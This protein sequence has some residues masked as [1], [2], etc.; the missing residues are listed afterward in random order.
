MSVRFYVADVL[1]E[2]KHLPSPDVVFARGV[3]HTFK[4]HKGRTAFAE[5]VAE[6]L[7]PGHLWLDVSGS[8]D[9]PAD[10]SD[11]AERGWPRLTLAQIAEA[12][13]P[14]F[15]VVSAR[16]AIYG[17]TAGLTDFRA[18]ACVFRRRFEFANPS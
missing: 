17:T 15:E 1:A 10:P 7:P 16:Q 6:I 12:V 5:A 9:T 3:L 18:F 4:H 2:R 8:A 13:E 11:A 14:R